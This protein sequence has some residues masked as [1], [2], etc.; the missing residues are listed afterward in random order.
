L[1]LMPFLGSRNVPNLLK[2]GLTMTVSLILLPLVKINPQNLPSEPYQFVF[3]MIGELLIGFILGL[4]V[5]L[6]FSGLQMGGL[7]AGFQMGLGMA[8][9]INPQSGINEPLL[10]QFYYLLGILI[11]LSI[12]GHHWFFRALAQSFNLLPPGEIYLRFPLYDHLVSLAGNMFVI[13]VKIAV[14]VLAVLIFTQMAL[15]ILAK[16]APQVNILMISFPLTIGLGFLI[17]GLSLDLL[18]PYFRALFEESG[19][20]LVFKLLPLMQR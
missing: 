20:G 12:D 9:I 19:K 13:G 14:P 3:L 5:K 18:L 10:S 1:F 16:A 4:S 8:N 11:F 2:I 6:I 7:L 15:G 17:L